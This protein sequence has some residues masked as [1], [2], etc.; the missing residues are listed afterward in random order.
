MPDLCPICARMRALLP[1]GVY[2]IQRTYAKVLT[3]SPPQL[4]T[5]ANQAAPTL[6]KASA[7]DEGSIINKGFPNLDIHIFARLRL[8][9]RNT[10]NGGKQNRGEYS[11][12]PRFVLYFLG[13]LLSLPPPEGLPVVLGHPALFL[14]VI[15]QILI[16]LPT[17][18]AFRH[19]HRQMSA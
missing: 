11:L 5:I 19:P 6:E 3:H 10:N 13:G 1:K 9:V 17:L 18:Y 12:S 14:H 8:L 7:L 2:D 16:V 15:T 4:K